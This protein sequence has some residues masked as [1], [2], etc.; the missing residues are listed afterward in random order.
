MY[1]ALLCLISG[2]TD[3][4][5]AVEAARSR[6]VALLSPRPFGLRAR[7]EEI[8]N[9][10][11]RYGGLRIT[12]DPELSRDRYELISDTILGMTLD[13]VKKLLGEEASDF[14]LFGDFGALIVADYARSG[15]RVTFNN[16]RAS[17]A[18]QWR[19]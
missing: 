3:M 2:A 8:L 14:S 17:S 4:S 5:P 7:R 1:A 9:S 13:E 10:S 11:E 6:V 18:V 16:G 19:E 12:L 15:W